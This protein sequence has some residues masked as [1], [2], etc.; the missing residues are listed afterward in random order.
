MPRTA[1]QR[2]TRPMDLA[3][4]ALDTLRSATFPI[5]AV[6]PS[7]WPGD[8][9]VGGVWGNGKHPLAVTMR[10]DDD[11]LIEHRSRRIEITSTGPEGLRHKAP[12]DAFLLWEHSYSSAIINFVPN[13]TRE[14]LPERPIPGSERFNAEMVDGKMTP[15]T[16]HL[17]SAGRRQL[18]DAVP[19][20][21]GYQIE[22]VAFEEMPKL[23]LYR[24]QMLDAEVVMLAW[25][26][27]D[28]EELRQFI[29]PARSIKDDKGLFGEIERAEYAAWQKIRQRDHGKD[30]T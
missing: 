23:R 4:E 26:R 21:D 15:R 18:I 17:Q 1:E 22:R 9:M 28:D 29:T 10:Y 19:F 12:H 7:R 14:R 16:V 20:I 3:K 8:V 13:V 30:S 5:F 11:L 25:G 6:P 24:A 27:D 2:E